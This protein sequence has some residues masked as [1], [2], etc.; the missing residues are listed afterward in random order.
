[1]NTPVRCTCN[2]WEFGV[3]TA[4]GLCEH[5]PEGC[6][7]CPG[8]DE[9]DLRPCDCAPGDPGRMTPQWWCVGCHEW[10]PNDDGSPPTHCCRC[11]CV[12]TPAGAALPHPRWDAD[13]QAATAAEESEQP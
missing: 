11:L 4:T 13:K 1:M 7:N 10:T 5:W 8:A 12:L 2:E 9:D 6:A 3:S